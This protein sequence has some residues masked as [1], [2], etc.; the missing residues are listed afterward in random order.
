VCG[1]STYPGGMVIG[2][3]GYLGA[4]IIVEDMGVKKTWK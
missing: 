2:G 1:A 4:N 3:P